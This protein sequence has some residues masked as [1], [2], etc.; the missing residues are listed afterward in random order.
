MKILLIDHAKKHFEKQDIGRW[1]FLPLYFKKGGHK[2]LHIIKKDWRKFP[3]TYIKFKPDIIISTGFIG[4]IPILFRKLRLVK[5]PIIHD[6]NDYYTEIHGPRIGIAKAAFLEAYIIENSNYITTPSRYLFEK[7]RIYEKKAR[8]IGHGENLNLNQ[9][10]ANL[11]GKFKLIYVGDQNKYKKVN[12]IIEA[13]NG[14][15]CEL[16]LAG[17]INE[18]LLKIAPKN[19]QFLGKIPYNKVGAYIKAADVC[20]ITADQEN[21]KLHEYAK[22]GKVI[23]AYKGRISYFLT[24]LENAYICEDLRQGLIKL[25]K[26][27]KL[28][29]KLEKNIKK[30][31]TSSWNKIAEEYLTFLKDIIQK[32]K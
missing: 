17:T 3:L 14:L 6:W 29:K 10:K 16:Y 12:R 4:I 32:R 27:P 7:A 22:A 5:C 23:L 1:H 19:V 15:N 25:M 11:K 2:V 30:L 8:F 21:L 9:K 24:H 18:S 20:V 28:R 31:P 26:N 13:V